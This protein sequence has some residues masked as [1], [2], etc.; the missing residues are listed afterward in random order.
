[1]I[2]HDND[3][4]FIKKFKQ[5]LQYK[6]VKQILISVS[7]LAFVRLMKQYIK[8]IVITLKTVI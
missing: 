4:H 1:M 6:D 8:M 5:V 7:H 3:S 2:Y